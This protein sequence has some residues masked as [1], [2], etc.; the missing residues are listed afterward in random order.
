VD[1]GPTDK[2][3]QLAPDEMRYHDL[4]MF[5]LAYL[6]S[7]KYADGKRV[8]WTTG[9]QF[10]T[11][12]D[13]DNFDVICSLRMPGVDHND[14]LTHE[15]WLK[16]LDSNADLKSKLEVARQSG[17][18][19]AEGVYTLLDKDNQFVV[20]GKGFVRIY[21][22]AKPG[23]RL[24]GISIRAEWLQPKEITGT[25]MGMNMTFDG[26]I[27][28]ATT[29]GYLVALSRDF[30]D[31][32]AIRLRGAV[33]EA[34]KQPQGVF[35]VRNGFCID[36]KGGIYVASHR[37]LHKVVWIGDKLSTDEK[38][39]AWT[40]PYSNSLGRGTGSTPT[41]VGF[42]NEP[43]KLVVLTDGDTLMNVVAYWRDQIPEGWKQLSPAPSRRIAGMQPANFGD[44]KLKAAQSEQSMVCSG[45]GMFVVN[46]EPRNVPRE[47]VDNPLDKFLFIGYLSYLKDYAPRGGQKFEWDPET[48]T[49]KSA[50]VNTEVSSPNCVPFVSTASNTVYLSGARDSEWTLEAI[51]WTTGKGTFHYILGGARFNSFYSQPAIDDQGRVMVSALYGSLRIQPKK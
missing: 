21:G 39:G 20:G 28:L 27:V 45:Y 12:F 40:E 36:E 3:R 50:W 30:K 32:Q 10:I 8:V 6:V 44:P 33:E 46:N 47:I 2:T 38:D 1:A 17:V 22:D 5:N 16:V 43:D 23:D 34:P 41:L 51:D 13:Y 19:T 31:V 37:H 25:F 18:P 29:D 48:K 9:S 35:W 42:G 15:T 14:H 7:G 11:K 4:G 49:L 24:S 26:R